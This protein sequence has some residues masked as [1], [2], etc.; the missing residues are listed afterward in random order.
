MLSVQVYEINER[1]YFHLRTVFEG[2]SFNK[3][4]YDYYACDN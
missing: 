3:I 2:R 1:S 4:S